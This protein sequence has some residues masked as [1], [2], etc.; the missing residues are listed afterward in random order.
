VIN[1]KLIHDGSSQGAFIAVSNE[2]VLVV[3]GV[4]IQAETARCVFIEF[5][6]FLCVCLCVCKHVV[7]F[8][9]CF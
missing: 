1:L 2:G 6:C 4:Q 3:N 9:S 7:N 5:R 8:A